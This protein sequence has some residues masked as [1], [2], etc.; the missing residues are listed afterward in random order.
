MSA[1]TPRAAWKTVRQRDSYS[2]LDRRVGNVSGEFGG[3]PRFG[4]PES[5]LAEPGDH[6]IPAGLLRCGSF[7]SL[8][9]FCSCLRFGLISCSSCHGRPCAPCLRFDL[10]SCSSCH[11]RPCAPLC[12]SLLSLFP[13]VPHEFSSKHDFG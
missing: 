2:L 12:S 1:A 3:I 4:C 10:I 13:F 7:P 6:L 11:G 9:F 8:R 5:E